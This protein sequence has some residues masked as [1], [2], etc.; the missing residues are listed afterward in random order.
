MITSAA[1][2]LI[3]FLHVT[4][5]ITGA[6]SREGT[7]GFSDAIGRSNGLEDEFESGT[8]REPFR[9]KQDGLMLDVLGGPKVLIMT[10]V[11]NIT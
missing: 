9:R 6:S 1:L 4:K 10:H 3:K 8:L 7:G 2:A 11:Y 5:P